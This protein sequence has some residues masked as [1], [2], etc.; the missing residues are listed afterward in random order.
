M[1]HGSARVGVGLRFGGGG[2]TERERERER[3][4]YPIYD[5]HWCY[6]SM[7]GIL[8]WLKDWRDVYLPIYLEM[9][10]RGGRGEER[11]E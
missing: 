7:V 3:G 11:R 8:A 10:Y 6:F 4:L 9:I 1:Q 2:G 5:I